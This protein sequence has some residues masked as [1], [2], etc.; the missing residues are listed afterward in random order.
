MDF[1]FQNLCKLADPIR[2]KD[3]FIDFMQNSAFL[4]YITLQ[5][6]ELLQQMVLR[7]FPNHDEIDLDNIINYLI[8]FVLSSAKEES[9]SK[10]ECVFYNKSLERIKSAS[11]GLKEITLEIPSNGEKKKKTIISY[12]PSIASENRYYKKTVLN[13][14]ESINEQEE[15]VPRQEEKAESE[16]EESKYII[17]ENE[18]LGEDIEEIES[19]EI[20]ALLRDKA[21]MH[22]DTS[23]EART[24]IRMRESTQIEGLDN[25]NGLDSSENGEEISEESSDTT[26]AELDLQTQTTIPEHEEKIKLE[27]QQLSKS[28]SFSSHSF[29]PELSV[30]QIQS[31]NLP[32]NKKPLKIY[33]RKAMDSVLS[34]DEQLSNFKKQIFLSRNQN[35][36]SVELLSN[37]Q[38]K[39]WVEINNFQCCKLYGL[40]VY[41]NIHDLQS[42]IF[43]QV[44]TIANRNSIKKTKFN[45]PF[46]QLQVQLFSLAREK[47]I[48][49]EI[50]RK[51]LNTGITMDL[52]FLK[53]FRRLC[54]MQYF[55]Q[56]ELC[57]NLRNLEY[58]PLGLQKLNIKNIQKICNVRV[59]Y[60]VENHFSQD[61]L[62]EYIEQVA[63][64]YEK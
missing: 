47:K 56:E 36:K 10:E 34:Q 53:E 46:S 25:S 2:F 26:D 61:D 29:P 33:E 60:I 44:D 35:K 1:H 59:S 28:S 49:L 15:L 58:E 42:S 24:P 12:Y 7:L 11:M 5:Q 13:S 18:A 6:F 55:I 37:F 3:Y 54:A 48:K 40:L 22:R 14:F 62:F 52:V 20:N 63:S 17:E 21:S 31:E 19:P 8:L 41:F 39:D 38:S 16:E 51:C 30:S 23:E 50:S 64:V 9:L 32:Q 45:T 27:S 57:K 4:G 43:K